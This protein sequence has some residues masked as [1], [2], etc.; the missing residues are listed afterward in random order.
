MVCIAVSSNARAAPITKAAPRISSREI[1]P[2]SAAISSAPAID[3]LDDLA[4]RQDRAAVIAIGHLPDH[5][6]QQD[7]GDELHEAD[8]PEVER[9]AGQFVELPADRHHQHLVGHRGRHAREPELHERA[10][11]QDEVGVIGGHWS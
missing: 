6:H 4:G 9:I 3:R 5:Q 11:P 10:V 8:E 2:E 7:A 1:A